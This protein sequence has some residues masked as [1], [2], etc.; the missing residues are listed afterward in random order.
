MKVAIVTDAWSPQV[1]GVVT[2][3]R[4]TADTRERS[5]H[6]VSCRRAAAKW[7]WER[8]TAQF[9]SHLVRARDGENRS[10]AAGDGRN[11]AGAARL[12]GRS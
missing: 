5:G 12:S 8:A 2:T 10:A 11:L 9:L 4:R 7:T 6:E 1:N 3:L